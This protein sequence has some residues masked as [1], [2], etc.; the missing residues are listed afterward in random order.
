[1]AKEIIVLGDLFSSVITEGSGS[2]SIGVC[3]NTLPSATVTVSLVSRNSQFNL[4]ASSLNFTVSNW[5]VP[6]LITVSATSDGLVTTMKY[7]F[8]DLT[9][10]GGGYDAVTKTLAVSISDNTTYRPFQGSHGWIKPSFPTNN[11][12]SAKMDKLVLDLFN[13]NGV[14]SSY[15]LVSTVTTTSP[16]VTVLQ[17]GSSTNMP[18]S[19]WST[20]DKWKFR[21]TDSDGYNYDC[22][23][24][25]IKPN[26][27]VTRVNKLWVDLCGSGGEGHDLIWENMLPKGW[28]VLN[29]SYCPFNHE[30]TTNNPGITPGASVQQLVSAGV[31]KVGFMAYKLIINQIVN[32]VVKAMEGTTYTEVAISGISGSGFPSLVAAAILTKA[33]PN[34][35]IHNFY[36]RS[37]L[38]RGMNNVASVSGSAGAV[39][40]N[41]GL[42]RYGV[43]TESTSRISDMFRNTGWGDM[44]GAVLDSGG[45]MVIYGNTNDASGG[46]WTEAAYCTPVIK[47]KYPTTY[48]RYYGVYDT[49]AGRT[50]HAWANADFAGWA[51]S[52][53]TPAFTGIFNVLGI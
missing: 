13:G 49:I 2:Y 23:G 36:W 10:S 33:F 18:D 41:C 3:L 32:A 14:P 53:A 8:L 30:N 6:Q 52:G 15:T 50:T 22:I 45:V 21:N 40:T 51:A 47:L 12:L 1:M 7:D 48:T 24:N 38:L 28:D 9:C 4:S 46:S 37:S 20:I 44:V 31:D 26:V 39:G 16:T 42:W 34:T 29:M 25:L 5:N 43:S 19:T 27:A 11:S 35:I 17:D